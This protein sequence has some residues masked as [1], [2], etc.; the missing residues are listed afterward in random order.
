MPFRD[1]NTTRRYIRWQ[2]YGQG[3]ACRGLVCEHSAEALKVC[4][5][6]IAMRLIVNDTC[7]PHGFA[8]P[9]TNLAHRR[10]HGRGI[11][12]FPHP[13]SKWRVSEMPLWDRHNIWACLVWPGQHPRASVEPPKSDAAYHGMAVGIETSWPCR[14]W[15]LSCPRLPV[16]GSCCHTC[17][18]QG[19]LLRA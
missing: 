8:A 12:R 2:C 5:P 14:L 6:T 10:V 1:I 15:R 7:F 11:S 17:T 9:V 18:S 19:L 4:F 16:N 13:L 3:P